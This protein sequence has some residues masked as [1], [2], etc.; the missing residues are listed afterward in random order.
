MHSIFVS[1][2]A[3]RQAVGKEK[4]ATCHHS[5]LATQ[6][7][8]RTR[9]RSNPLALFPVLILTSTFLSF[10]LIYP[11]CRSE[12]LLVPH[13]SQWQWTTS[14]GPTHSTPSSPPASPAFAP[15]TPTRIYHPTTTSTTPLP[16]QF[17]PTKLQRH[18]RDYWRQMRAR[19]KQRRFR[20]IRILARG[21]SGG[22]RRERGIG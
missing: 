16:P 9:T 3:G 10:L 6:V 21:G 14:P 11:P 2:F 4:H 20:C 22:R 8:A 12:T 7:R 1:I 17:G 13:H 15:R 19:R 18:L 5:A